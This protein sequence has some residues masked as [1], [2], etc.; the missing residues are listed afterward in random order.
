MSTLA[1]RDEPV[2]F[3]IDRDPRF[4]QTLRTTVKSLGLRAEYYGSVEEFCQAVEAERSGCLVIDLQA[5][6]WSLDALFERLENEGISLPVLVVSARLDVPAIVEAI[7]TGALNYLEKSCGESRLSTA[8]K[9]A[10]AWDAE[11]RR[12]LLSVVRFQ[13]RLNRLTPG[14][15]EVLDLLVG[16]MSNR[17]VA[18][19]LGRS[20]RAIEV[21]RAKIRKKLKARGLADLVRQ[22]EALRRRAPLN[23]RRPPP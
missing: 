7:R 14:E 6:R 11:H 2:V 10:V 16:G 18:A 22:I 15:R 5:A 19:A 20:E 8:L 4:C 23:P 9:E 17:E 21:R 1:W 12:E 13:R 3:V